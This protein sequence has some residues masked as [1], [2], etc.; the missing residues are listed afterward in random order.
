M[1]DLDLFSDLSQ[2]QIEEKQM[3]I[4]I[5]FIA[6]NVLNIFVNLAHPQISP[7][8]TVTVIKVDTT[9]PEKDLR[10]KDQ[11]KRTMKNIDTNLALGVA[12]AL[13]GPYLW[14][15]EKGQCC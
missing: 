9:G 8:V 7:F 1:Y 4:R 14:K 2:G 12:K 15:I 11:R 13:V 6:V 10:M 3:S 5:I